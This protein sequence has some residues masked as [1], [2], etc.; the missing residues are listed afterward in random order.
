MLLVRDRHLG[1]SASNAGRCLQHVEQTF[2][3][4]NPSPG[5]PGYNPDHLLSVN[6]TANP[7]DTTNHTVSVVSNTGAAGLVPRKLTIR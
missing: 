4:S 6:L 5:V 3:I 2:L 1:A 7:N